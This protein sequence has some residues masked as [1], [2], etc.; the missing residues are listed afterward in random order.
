MSRLAPLLGGLAL[1]ASAVAAE[2]ELLP[3]RGDG[4]QDASRPRMD[5]VLLWQ[6]PAADVQLRESGGWSTVARGVVAPVRLRRVA[7]GAQVRLVR[8]G[9]PGEVVRFHP[10]WTPA[11]LAAWSGPGLRGAEVTALAGTPDAL[12]VGTTA[13]G[14]AR[15][16]GQA[17]SH[18]GRRDGLGSDAVVE[19]AR[20]GD[21]LWL[22]TPRGVAAL[23]PDGGRRWSVAELGGVPRGLAATPAG[24]WA[25]TDEGVVSVDDV[26]SPVLEASG[27]GRLLADGA[28]GVLALC[29]P[30]RRLPGGARV[31]WPEGVDDVVDAHPTARGV[32]FAVRGSEV[33]EVV[34]GETQDAVALPVARLR[35]V[36]PLGDGLV[37]AAGEDG[38]WWIS[39]QG[40][41]RL[42]EPAGLPSPRVLAVAPSGNAHT[43]WVGTDAGVALLSQDGTASPLPLA[44]LAAGRGVRAVAPG[45]GG[46]AVL[47]DTH[48]VWLGPRPPRGWTALAAAVGEAGRALVRGADDTVW[49]LVDGALL[50][51]DRKGVLA[52]WRLEEDAGS[53]AAGH[54]RLAVATPQGLRFW[55]PG[56]RGLSPEVTLDAAPRAVAVGEDGAVWA[57]LPDEVVR[58]EAGA[59]VAWPVD[60]V[61]A[62]VALGSGAVAAGDAGLWWLGPGGTLERLWSDHAVDGVVALAH[63][64]RR[65]WALTGQGELWTG[66]QGAPRPIAPDLL[67]LEGQP[68]GLQADREGVW[69]WTDQGAWRVRGAP[70]GQTSE[71]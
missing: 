46:V 27:C 32:A 1:G 9:T 52:R 69:L 24:A 6:G 37:A 2:V 64:G 36:A 19:L 11:D 70:G 8:E 13:G 39:D 25:S 7:P 20:Q 53:L 65:L 66:G 21:T 33:V 42:G 34:G 26:P 31:G 67:G 3:L 22:A 58:W 48:P 62:L 35:R 30:P 15:W 56:A 10:V 29:D 68:R 14:L 18:L 40:V 49:A 44:P 54:G 60:Q 12:W 38:L 43:A 55:I 57:A 17:W 63:D 47:A 71:R 41:R 4:P 50:S 16:D 59:L 51:L 61:R 5:A 45:R 28:D 23:A